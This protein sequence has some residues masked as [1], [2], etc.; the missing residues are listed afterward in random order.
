MITRTK[1]NEKKEENGVFDFVDHRCSVNG[2]VPMRQTIF[3]Q[4]AKSN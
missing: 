3:P 4:T 1:K 2:L